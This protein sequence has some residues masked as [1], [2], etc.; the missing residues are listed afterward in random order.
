[1]ILWIY[2]LT[3]NCKF[4]LYLISRYRLNKILS[5]VEWLNKIFYKWIF[6]LLQ[7]SG[8]FHCILWKVLE[9][10]AKPHLASTRHKMQQTFTKL[11]TVAITALSIHQAL[12][13]QH[14]PWALVYRG[15]SLDLT[16]PGPS[17][18]TT[19]LDSVHPVRE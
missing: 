16:I 15:I 9:K 12:R 5:F 8:I 1:M 7:T 10:P 19:F 4:S 14:H 11:L 2:P 3:S 6:L 17:N 18:F 13:G